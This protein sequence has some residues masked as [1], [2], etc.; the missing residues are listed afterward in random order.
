MKLNAIF[1][2]LQVSCVDEENAIKCGHQVKISFVIYR[3]SRNYVSNEIEHF[4]VLL[5]VQVDAGSKNG[6]FESQ[7]KLSVKYLSH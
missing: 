6:K 1:T 3:I 5:F 4:Q 2:S 7:C